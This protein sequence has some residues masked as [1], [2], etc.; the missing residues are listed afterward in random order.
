MRKDRDKNASGS[1]RISKP[2]AFHS[3]SQESDTP[4]MNLHDEE[5]YY[6]E[7]EDY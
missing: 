7:V 2:T 6:F 4:A 1:I 3:I 5:E